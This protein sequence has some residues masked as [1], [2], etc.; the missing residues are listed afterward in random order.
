[1]ALAVLAVAAAAVIAWIYV[2]T[3]LDAGSGRGWRLLTAAPHFAPARFL[4]FPETRPGL[5]AGAMSC[6]QCRSRFAS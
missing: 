2:T 3:N 4:D 1:M 6:R 5:V